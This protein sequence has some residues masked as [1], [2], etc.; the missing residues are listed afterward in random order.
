MTSEADPS[1]RVEL[2]RQRGGDPEISI[3]A[4]IDDKGNLLLSGQELGKSVR[5]YWSDDDYEYW[6]LVSKEHMDRLLLAMIKRL[7]AGN[8]NAVSELGQW[9]RENDIP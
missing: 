9:L 5:E 7:Y 3:D 6:L 8:T 4:A 1:K 2:C